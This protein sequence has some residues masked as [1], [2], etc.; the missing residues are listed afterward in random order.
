MVFDIT[1]WYDS[2][3]RDPMPS[4]NHYCH[5]P[6]TVSRKQVNN[7]HLITS[8]NFGTSPSVNRSKSSSL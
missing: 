4:W 2:I 5:I 7:E 1:M 6:F 8:E 3:N